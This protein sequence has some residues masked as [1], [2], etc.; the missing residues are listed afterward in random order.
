MARHEFAIVFPKRTFKRGKT[1]IWRITRS[2]PLP[3][4]SKETRENAA[5]IRRRLQKIR[6]AHPNNPGE[7]LGDAAEDNRLKRS[8]AVGQ[9]AVNSMRKGSAFESSESIQVPEFGGRLEAKED[10]SSQ[11][12]AFSDVP[13]GI[14]QFEFKSNILTLNSNFK[15]KFNFKFKS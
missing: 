15:V 7:I 11:L 13:V 1:R 12:V 5:I 2:S 3:Y 6:E 14:K 9:A 4:V 8:V 10:S